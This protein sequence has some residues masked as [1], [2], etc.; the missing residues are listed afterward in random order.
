MNTI[1]LVVVTQQDLTG[2]GIWW[3]ENKEHDNYMKNMIN[4]YSE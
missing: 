4:Y 3:Y 1:D 2:S